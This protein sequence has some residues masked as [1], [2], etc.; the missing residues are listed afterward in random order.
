[1]LCLDCPDRR[2]CASACP[3][4]TRELKRIEGYQREL[5][6]PPEKLTV[7]A[8]RSARSLADV[9]PDTPFLW[10]DLAG[11]VS[12][13]PPALGVTFVLHYQQGLPVGKVARVLGINRVTVNRRLK[14]GR[15]LVRRKV[16]MNGGARLPSRE[17]GA[18][19]WLDD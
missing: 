17:A 6:L 4:L 16:S 12:E 3:A 7:A 11:P 9:F 8:E 2:N 14:K 19:S 15:A 10:D 18:P 13:L 5:P 1:M